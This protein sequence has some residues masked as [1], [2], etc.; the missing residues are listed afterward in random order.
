MVRV[1]EAKKKKS[2]WGGI[3]RTK[4]H[5][6]RKGKRKHSSRKRPKEGPESSAASAGEGKKAAG[7]ENGERFVR[8]SVLMGEKA[9]EKTSVGDV[10]AS[11]SSQEGGYLNSTVPASSGKPQKVCV[12][13]SCSTRRF[14]S[15]ADLLQAAALD[16]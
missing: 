16:H 13:F 9:G 1:P 7:E 12:G 8:E 10:S 4:K 2:T 15:H 3:H 14:G 11:A 6:T 5:G